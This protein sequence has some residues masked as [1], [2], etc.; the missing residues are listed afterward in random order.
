MSSL[1]SQLTKIITRKKPRVGR[2]Y[3]SGHGGHTS[4]RG[5][6]GAKAR[7]KVS[8]IFTGTK[9]KKS[10]W[11]RLPVM[12]GRGFFKPQKPTLTITLRQIAPFIKKTNQ[13]ID[14]QFLLDHKIISL[15]QAKTHKIKLVATGTLPKPI[16]LQLPAS[17]AV[18]DLINQ[19][20]NQSSSKKTQ[21]QK[22]TTKSS[23]KT[24]IAKS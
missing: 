3:G 12:R 21:T 13:T 17:Q 20:K 1:L 19:L 5:S 18:L 14:L 6:K 4:G 22:T 15:K 10:L 9:H 24:K 16:N 7:G 8:I 23:A 2:G 11:Q